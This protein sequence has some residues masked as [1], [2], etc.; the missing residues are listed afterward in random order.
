MYLQSSTDREID[1]WFQSDATCHELY[2]QAIRDMARRHWT[3][4]L[5]AKKASGFLATEPGAKIL[6]I[7]SGAGKFCLA[8]AFYQPKLQFTGV[9][10][11]AYLVDYANAALKQTGQDNVS[12]INAN[13]T[14]INFRQYDHFYFYNSFY[15]NLACTEKID[16]DVE[17]SVELFEYYSHYLCKQL[18][19][20]PKGTRL[21]TY[22]SLETE[23]PPDFHVVNT[24]VNDY[25][26]CWIKI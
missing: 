23:I 10:Q 22:H 3:P 18:Y 9:E 17:H 15:E 21:V 19:N 4:L 11:R 13:F 16:K 7:G 8:A 24:D 6:D 14:Q 26:K 1:K 2:P 20:V 5:V 25:L 12:F